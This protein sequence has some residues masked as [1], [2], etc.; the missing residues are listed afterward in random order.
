MKA[1]TDHQTGPDYWFTKS[2]TRVM[3]ENIGINIHPGKLRD[4]LDWAEPHLLWPYIDLLLHGENDAM[5]DEVINFLLGPMAVSLKERGLGFGQCNEIISARGM[6]TFMEALRLGLIPKSIR[7]DF[8]VAFIQRFTKECRAT[9]GLDMDVERTVFYS[10]LADVVEPMFSGPSSSAL[11]EAIDKIM[12][13][14]PGQVEKA[15]AEPKLIGWFIGQVGKT[16]GQK[17]DPHTVRTIIE[18]KL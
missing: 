8:D 15:R 12:A 4:L 18:A 10:I 5:V 11:E 2:S 6:L 1:Y 17:L 13:E 14:N 3:V 16:M 7:K 9:Y